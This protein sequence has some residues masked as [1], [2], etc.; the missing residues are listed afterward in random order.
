V[1]GEPVVR[2]LL[3]GREFVHDPVVVLLGHL[4]GK[5]R[6]EDLQVAGPG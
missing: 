6:R 3:P 1:C 5:D 4:Q 2:E